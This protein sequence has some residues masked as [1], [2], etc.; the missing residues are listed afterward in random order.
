MARQLCEAGADKDKAR[1]DGASTLMAAS[2]AGHLEV[3]RL[4]CEAGVDKDKAANA[5]D[6]MH[7]SATALILAWTNTSLHRRW[8]W[9]PARPGAAA[10]FPFGI[11]R[12]TWS[13]G[14]ANIYIYIYIYIYTAYIYIYIDR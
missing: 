10:M 5:G 3:A 9:T 6:A 12:E 1:Q 2:E 8:R 4:L 11:G 14:K 13:G 7:V